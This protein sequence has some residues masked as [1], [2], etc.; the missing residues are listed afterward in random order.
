[1]ASSRF[2]NLK[3]FIKI[4]GPA[5]GTVEAAHHTH[6]K[7]ILDEHGCHNTTIEVEYRDETGKVHVTEASPYIGAPAS[8]LQAA[9]DKADV[10]KAAYI[11]RIASAQ[12]CS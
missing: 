5:V 9:I 12:A 10:A 1:M 4:T 2:V 11:S 7:S 6:A 3:Q 8:A